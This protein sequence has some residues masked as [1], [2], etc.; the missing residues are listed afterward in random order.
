MAREHHHL[1][2][3]TKFFQEVERGEKKFELRKNDR[4]FKRH[5][6]VYLNEIVGGVHTGRQIGPLEIRYVLT[7]KAGGRFGLCKGYCIFCW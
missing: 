2:C 1:K 6:M 4:H 3:E 5:D 7:D